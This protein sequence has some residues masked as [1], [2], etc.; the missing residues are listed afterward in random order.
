MRGISGAETDANRPTDTREMGIRLALGA[1]PASILS[2]VLREGLA[3]CGAGMESRKYIGLDV[4]GSF[5]A[6]ILTMETSI[7]ACA[8]AGGACYLLA[9]L[10]VPIK[11]AVADLAG[12][13]H[14]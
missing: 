1:A 7:A 5:V 14:A 11:S 10:S 8:L 2:Q 3:L 4:H 9:G 6:I 13:A 12:A